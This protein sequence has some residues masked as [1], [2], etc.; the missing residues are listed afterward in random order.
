MRYKYNLDDP[1]GMR[2]FQKFALLEGVSY[3]ID[4]IDQKMPLESQL[5]WT[6]NGL[7]QDFYAEY[8]DNIS[9]FTNDYWG[10]F[11]IFEKLFAKAFK[12]YYTGWHNLEVTQ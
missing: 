4:I 9:R 8:H 10:S 7:L 1:V 5:E 3:A 2:R 6:A 12:S 11:S